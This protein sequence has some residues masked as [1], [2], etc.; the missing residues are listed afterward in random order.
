MIFVRIVALSDSHGSYRA[1]EKVILRNGDA[2]MFVHLGDG[3]RDVDVLRGKYPLLDIRC[4]SGNCDFLG[5]A[6]PVHIIDTKHARIFC[7]H[8]HRYRV[9]SGLES[10]RSA[11]LQN[12]CNVVLYGHTHQRYSNYSA[13]VY[14][15]NPGS[16]Y[17]PRD[18]NPP[19]YGYIDLTDAGIVTNHVDL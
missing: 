9:K 3:E 5:E 16:C 17:E 18:G 10:L 11:A 19:S 14:F 12:N 7:V 15:L 6:Q 8:G 13:G 4:V 1:A 2:D